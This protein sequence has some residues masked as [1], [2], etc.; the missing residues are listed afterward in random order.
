MKTIIYISV[1]FFLSF[2][3]SC[4][5]TKEEDKPKDI[6]A[7]VK[8]SKVNSV[9]ASFSDSFSGKIKSD[10][11]STLSTTLMGTIQHVLVNQGDMVSKGDVLIRI[12]AQAL[13]AENKQIDANIKIAKYALEN[14]RKNY[15][16]YKILLQQESISQKEMDDMLTNFNVAKSKYQVTLQMKKQLQESLNFAIIK[17][18]YNAYVTKRFVNNGDMASPGMPLLMLDEIGKLKVVLSIPPKETINLKR[19]QLAK[20][21]IDALGDKMFSAKIMSI[22]NSSQNANYQIEL[23]I[24]DTSDLARNIYPGMYASVFFNSAKDKSI[25]IDNKV[26][27]HKGQLT[28]LYIYSK[29]NV[30]LLRWISVGDHKNDKVEI[31]TGLSVG[32]EYITASDMRLFDG[33]KVNVLK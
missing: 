7:N 32:E 31:L 28:G 33:L 14:T 6:V 10:V 29:Q 2:L 9:L 19:N 12:N 24:S 8:I 27:V 16:R 20:V 13:N 25:Y 26:L 1:I 30:A 4:N 22:N 3:S 15:N 21:K 11:S 18:P 23:S 5:S 17:A